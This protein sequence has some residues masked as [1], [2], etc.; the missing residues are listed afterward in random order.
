MDHSAKVDGDQIIVEVGAAR[1]V[2]TVEEA[3]ALAGEMVEAAS[4]ACEKVKG[5]RTFHCTRVG[6]D[7][8]E[9]GHSSAEPDDI[10]FQFSGSYSM[11]IH[12]SPHDVGALIDE[13][14]SMR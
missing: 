3:V 1:R 13:L 9:I 12:L 5:R 11:A 4:T 7:T 10:I 8:L 2:L 14:K 6:S